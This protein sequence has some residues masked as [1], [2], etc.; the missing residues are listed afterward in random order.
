MI[1]QGKETA[2]SGKYLRAMDHPW[3]LIKIVS[4]TALKNAKP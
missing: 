1:R 3:F 2:A 4:V